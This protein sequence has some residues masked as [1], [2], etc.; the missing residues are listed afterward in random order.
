MLCLLVLLCSVFCFR[1][2]VFVLLSFGF[3]FQIGKREAEEV[4]EKQQVPAKKQKQNQA[5]LKQAIAKKNAEAKI[6]KNT[7]AESGSEDDSDADD[8]GLEDDVCACVVFCKILC[9]FC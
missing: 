9:S 6:P 2:W 4:T 1:V 7:K 5:A 3:L 8:S